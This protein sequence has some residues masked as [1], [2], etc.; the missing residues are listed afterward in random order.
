MLLCNK[1]IIRKANMYILRHFN[2]ST[3]NFISNKYVYFVIE[4]VKNKQE[5]NTMKQPTILIDQVK[6]LNIYCFIS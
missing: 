5:I 3:S 1:Q 6:I 2:P 4:S